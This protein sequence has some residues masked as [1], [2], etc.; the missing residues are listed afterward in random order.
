MVLEK[1]DGT[2]QAVDVSN[3]LGEWVNV[4]AHTDF[5]YDLQMSLQDHKLILRVLSSNTDIAD[6]TPLEAVPFPVEQSTTVAGFYI[7]SSQVDLTIAANEKFGILVL[8]C[9]LPVNTEYSE[10]Y[11]LT[12]EFYCRKPDLQAKLK[13]QQFRQRVT[14][15]NPHFQNHYDNLIGDWKNTR[16]DTAWVNR[17]IIAQDADKW[18]MQAFADSDKYEWPVTDLTPYFFDGEEMG[19]VAKACT[20]HLTSLFTAY[21][22][23]GLIVITAFHHVG[24]GGHAQKYFCREFYVNTQK[25]VAVSNRLVEAK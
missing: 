22:N 6:A 5:I 1:V 9:Y 8:Q 15:V 10:G 17:I 24:S 11:Q 4:N 13:N 2:Q 3:L 20:N 12:R 7:Y 25:V 23:K 14:H 16:A 18:Q 19:F 21:S